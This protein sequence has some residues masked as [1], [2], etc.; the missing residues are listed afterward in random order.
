MIPPNG[1]T[2][3]ACPQGSRANK[4][5][6]SPRGGA[7]RPSGDPVAGI[8]TGRSFV[9]EAHQD[10]DLHHDIESITEALLAQAAGG[11][12]SSAEVGRSLE[13]AQIP[14]SQATTV[15]RA[16]TDAGVLVLDGTLT[17]RA[18][19]LA[20]RSA[21]AASKATTVKA[22]PDDTPDDTPPAKAARA[23]RSR[24][25]KLAAVPDAVDEPAEDGD[26]TAKVAKAA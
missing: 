5:T 8:A 17:K 16:L 3:H 2:I 20:A 13:R 26:A 7:P 9:T 18:A 23:T 19:V 15:I 21:T 6:R 12:L 24:S 10:P 22:V 25:A 1:A 4:E 11:Q 14:P